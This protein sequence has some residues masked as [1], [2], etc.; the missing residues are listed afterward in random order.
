ML[1]IAHFPH[2]IQQYIICT[3]AIPSNIVEQS[4]LLRNNS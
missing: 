2:K 3:L 4:E 1:V